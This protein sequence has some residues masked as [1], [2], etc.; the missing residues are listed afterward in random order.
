M[1]KIIILTVFLLSTAC[2]KKGSGTPAK[3]LLFSSAVTSSIVTAGGALITG[4]NSS[5]DSFQIGLQNA[6]DGVDIEL[7]PGDWEFSAITWQN[8]NGNGLLT[9]TNRCAY[10]SANIGGEEVVINLNLNLATCGNPIFSRTE[11]SNGNQFKEL[12]LIACA[13]L[14]GVVDEYSSCSTNPFK[15]GNNL[16]YRILFKGKKLPENVS[17]PSLSSGCINT[18]D[19]T[20]S[21]Y[22]TNY[23][24]PL[25]DRNNFPFVIMAYESLNC[26]SDEFEAGYVFQTDSLKNADSIIHGTAGGTNPVSFFFADNYIGKSGNTFANSS[27]LPPFQNFTNRYVDPTS[28]EGGGNA[29]DNTRNSFIG[30]V[31]AT[32]LKPYWRLGSKGKTQVFDSSNNILSISTIA[33]TDQYNGMNFDFNYAGTGTECAVSDSYSASSKTLTINY[34]DKINN[35]PTY[36]IT[37]DIVNA[38]N[39]SLSANSLDPD[40]VVTNNLPG[41]TIS[42]P[43]TTSVSIDFGRA[44]EEIDRRDTG[45]YGEIARAYHTYLG[46]L[47]FKAGYNNCSE[48]PT[49]GSYTYFLDEND[50]VELKFSTGKVPMTEWMASSGTYPYKNI[51]EKRIALFQE[52]QMSE[53]YEFNCSGNTLAGFYRSTHTDDDGSGNEYAVE[54]Y[55]D[56]QSADD[57]KFEY[58]TFDKNNETSNQS[59]R[60]QWTYFQNS[61]ASNYFELWTARQFNDITNSNNQGDIYVA[62]VNNTNI[63]TSSRNFTTAELQV[64]PIDFA[65]DTPSKNKYEYDGTFVSGTGH[66]FAPPYPPSTL[67]M[68]TLSFKKLLDAVPLNMAPMTMEDSRILPEHGPN[69]TYQ[70]FKRTMDF[71]DDWNT[72]N[73]SP[74]GCLTDEVEMH[75]FLLDQSTSL[76]PSSINYVY[77]N[78]AQSVY[79]LLPI[80]TTNGGCTGIEWD[81][82]FSAISIFPDSISNVDGN[83][84]TSF[85]VLDTGTKFNFATT[86]TLTA[87]NTTQNFS[88]TLVSTNEAISSGQNKGSLRLLGDQVYAALVIDPLPVVYDDALSFSSTVSGVYPGANISI[89]SNGSGPGTCSFTD[90]AKTIFTCDSDGTQASNDIWTIT[91]DNP[92]LS[93]TMSDT[94][95]V[96]P[97]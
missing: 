30:I 21:D 26:Q 80:F 62:K 9:G 70:I 93:R 88:D 2:S 48:I 89:T 17:L 68:N 96:Q 46:A 78:S 1:K 14:N 72:K 47:L 82:R 83:P 5:G 11:N 29:Y 59:E 31:G 64:T 94:L 71:F 60:R 4:K 37:D 91:I 38:I 19:L 35:T 43:I 44:S 57:L 40:L 28:S 50:S 20:V 77:S 23:K 10:T 39:A 36:T 25:N 97:L 33:N 53:F 90:T 8:E 55:Y 12:K 3:L 63:Y 27:M 16:S 66:D 85:Q 67:A 7:A 76:F 6:N 79:D 75:D 92:S 69:V 65:N 54:A 18:T 52:G 22:I 24:L 61:N 45:L 73:I 13:N 95:T 56:A 81:S 58:T 32:N 49:T 51:F 87:T 86:Y 74:Q 34:C 41:T 15:Q 84:P 42:S